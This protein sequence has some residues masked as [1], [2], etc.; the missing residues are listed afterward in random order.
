MVEETDRF[1]EHS[2][3]YDG[4]KVCSYLL[5]LFWRVEMDLYRQRG[6]CCPRFGVAISV[7]SGSTL[8]AAA[9]VPSMHFCWAEE[10]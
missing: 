4:K 10:T 7:S 9:E 8:T 6:K 1:L 3:I 5:D 2:T